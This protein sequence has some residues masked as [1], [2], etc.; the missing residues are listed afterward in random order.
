MERLCSELERRGTAG[1]TDGCRELIERLEA[2]LPTT[3]VELRERLL[4]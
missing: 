2:A 3:S 4:D 1:S